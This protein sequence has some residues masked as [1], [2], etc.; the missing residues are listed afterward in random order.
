M[1]YEEVNPGE[2]QVDPKTGERFRMVGHIKEYEMMVHTS[3][4]IVPAS[5]LAEH[6]KRQKEAEERR[7]AAAEEAW[8]NRPPAKSCPFANGCNTLCKREQCKIFYD[9]KCSIATVAD[10][11]GVEIEEAP[12][13]GKKCPFSIYGH[14]D[15]CALYNKGCAVV[16]MAAAATNK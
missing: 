4:G 6:N 13:K 16:R 1:R 8:R 15:G 5:E 2:W 10:A 11:V 12:A 7:K 14:C 3:G 9:G